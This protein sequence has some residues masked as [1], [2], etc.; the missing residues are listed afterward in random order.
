M[1]FLS[2]EEEMG[3]RDSLN[4]AAAGHGRVQ[5]ARKWVK[6]QIVADGIPA[7]FHVKCVDSP[8]LPELENYNSSNGSSCS[9]KRQKRAR[10]VHVDERAAA[11]SSG[12]FSVSPAP[13]QRLFAPSK[14]KC[15]ECCPHMEEDEEE[16]GSFVCI[17][18]LSCRCS[19]CRKAIGS[20]GGGRWALA[21]A[22]HAAKGRSAQ[23][24]E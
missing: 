9:S 16:E 13:P 20:G 5:R 6:L 7:P 24:G 21:S 22:A 3:S 15:R 17:S 2:G 19:S 8:R 12:A 14:M 18:C 1:G 10:L 11:A 23:L 4:V